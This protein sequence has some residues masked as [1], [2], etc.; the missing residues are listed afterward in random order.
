[1][2]DDDGTPQAILAINTDITEKK[3]L[4][5]QFLRA[6]RM[7]SIGTL[8]GGIA[9]DLNNVL[10][11]IMMSIELLRLTSRDERAQ[12]MLSTIETSAKRGADMVQQILSFARG[13]EG[14]RVK[15]NVRQII[16]EMQHL[17]QDTFPKNIVFH[18]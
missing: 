5:Q 3:R 13:V 7:E 14:Q 15:I 2:R 17:V 4:E 12:S 9:H 18:S 8:A 10:A 16:E 1:V 11:P 6:Q